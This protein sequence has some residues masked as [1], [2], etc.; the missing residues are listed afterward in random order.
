MRLI[1]EPSARELGIINP[2]ACLIQNIA[3]KPAP[4]A[5][6]AE[7]DKRL[8]ILQ[9][10]HQQILSAP[11]TTGFAE[12]F[13]KMGYP[14]QTPAGQRMIETTLA[15]GLTSYNNVIDAY[16]VV[17]VMH[18]C[19]LGLHDVS[20][21]HGDLHVRRADGSETIV[22]MFK[23]GSKPVNAGDLVYGL[24]SPSAPEQRT[25]LAWLGKRDVD[26]D[27][28]KV[29]DQSTSLLLVVL[30]NARTSREH[31]A[32]ICREVLDLLRLSCPEA[33]ETFVDQS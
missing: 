6:R 24:A 15:R 8:D 19:G 4:P 18:G 11:E 26:S 9:Q 23:S 14:D 20:G 33:R 28:F 16:N 5:L 30:G 1:I 10:T 32:S 22:P 29:T 3:I 25:L 2:V 12:L 31:N 17:S 7:I 21:Y 27:T 13:A